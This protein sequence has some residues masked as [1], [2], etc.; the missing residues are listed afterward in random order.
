MIE[1][2]AKYVREVDYSSRGLKG[3][4]ENLTLKVR[5]GARDDIEEALKGVHA[6]EEE[7][8]RVVQTEIS[9]LKKR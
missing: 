4:F 7:R 1:E 2:L 5:Q 8:E 6:R 3:E 9:Q